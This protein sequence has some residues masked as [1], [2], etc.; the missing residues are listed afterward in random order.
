MECV[1]S[2]VSPACLPAAAQTRD[3]EG[4]TALRREL[5]LVVL[6]RRSGKHMACTPGAGRRMTS[7]S[8]SSSAMRRAS[9]IASQ[10]CLAGGDK[11]NKGV[12]LCYQT[13]RETHAH[14]LLCHSSKAAGLCIQGSPQPPES[15]S[16]TARLLSLL[17]NQ[18]FQPARDLLGRTSSD[19]D[20]NPPFRPSSPTENAKLFP[21]SGVRTQPS[22]FS[23]YSPLLVTSPLSRTQPCF[24]RPF[25][26]ST[27][28]LP[29][30]SSHFT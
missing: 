17:Q 8:S 19:R 27:K 20:D 22:S 9:C 4:L 15:F 7:F 29:R 24:S 12:F 14:P 11:G 23:T 30:A 21:K 1:W 5:T 16:R 10:V 3:A 2:C 13:R 18:T 25:T 26:Q 28:S 6:R